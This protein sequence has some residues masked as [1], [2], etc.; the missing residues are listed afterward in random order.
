LIRRQRVKM[1]SI[2]E[3]RY[4]WFYLSLSPSPVRHHGNDD[5]DDAASSLKHD[6]TPLSLR[7]TLILYL[8]ISI[9]LL[10]D[11][12]HSSPLLS[13]H[14]GTVRAVMFNLVKEVETLYVRKRDPYLSHFTYV[15]IQANR[16]QWPRGL[17]RGSA[18]ARLLGS[19][20][21]IPTGG[22]DVCLL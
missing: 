18:A 3:F 5:D 8:H 2:R 15:M 4:P 1:Q 20:V 17:R 10:C 21:R 7:P 19:W 9:Y 13:R 12:H 22:M 11:L 14:A 16:S 6:P